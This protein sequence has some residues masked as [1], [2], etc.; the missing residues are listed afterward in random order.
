[1]HRKKEVENEEEKKRRLGEGRG[2]EIVK[3]K[4]RQ[5][6]TKRGQRQTEREGKTDLF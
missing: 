3:E 4:D 1:M 2:V 5:T 6:G